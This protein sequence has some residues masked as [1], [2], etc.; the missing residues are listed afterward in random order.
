ME[1]AYFPLLKKGDTIGIITPSSGLGKLFPHRLDRA[2]K[3]LES[4]GYKVKEFQNSRKNNGWESAPAIDRAKEI[5]DAFLD[6]EVKAIICEIGGNTANK[7]LKYLNFK[8]IKSNPKIFLGYSDISVLHYALNSK[9]GFTTFYGPC[10]MTQF[11]EFPT[12]LDHTIQFFNKAIV[13][14]KIGKIE[15]SKEWTS[16]VLDWGKKLDIQRPRK[17]NPN[18][19]YEWL[20]YGSAK[21]K[22]LGGCLSSITHLLGT[23]YWPNHKNS[24]L[25]LELAQGSS[26]D[27]GTPLAEVDALLADL[28]IAGIFN[29]I[30]GLVIG[31]PFE[32]S[33]EEEEKFKE[34][35]M[36]NTKDYKFPILY[37]VDVGH[38]DPQITIP[39]GINAELDSTKNIFK[40]EF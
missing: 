17:M 6:N 19:G 24:I 20:R 34:I 35:I 14:G 12:P 4:Q 27:K 26:F 15:P 30:K 36:D 13:D 18:K 5:M 31:R 11:G 29:Q 28:E 40:L 3:Y 21:G 16:E 9:C 39:L 22:I 32:Y 7:T 37:G 1:K 8:K 10:I 23:E 2:I 38:T 33:S 25:F